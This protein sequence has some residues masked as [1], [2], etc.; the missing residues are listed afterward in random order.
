MISFTR[1]ILLFFIIIVSASA[2][3]GERE[4]KAVPKILGTYAKSTVRKSLFEQGV[5]LEAQESG[6][7]KPNIKKLIY[8][9]ERFKRLVE[10]L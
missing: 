4:A 3:S 6:D 5:F 1:S 10:S 2:I 8:Q 7:K 9:S